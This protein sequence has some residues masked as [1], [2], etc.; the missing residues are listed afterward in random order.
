MFLRYRVGFVDFI[1]V[2]I[3]YFLYR[4]FDE[5]NMDYILVNERLSLFKQRD[6]VYVKY[7]KV[8]VKIF[9]GLLSR[10][11]VMVVLFMEIFLKYRF[12]LYYG[13]KFLSF[14]FLVLNVNFKEQIFI[15]LKFLEEEMIVDREI[16]KEEDYKNW[17]KER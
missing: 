6:L 16:K 2:D 12:G 9:G 3:S 10:K 4:F 13:R 15:E 1:D 5:Y 17:M 11:R 14:F 8:V 7:Y